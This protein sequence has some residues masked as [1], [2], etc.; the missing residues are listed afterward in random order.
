MEKCPGGRCEGFG[1]PARASNPPPGMAS[2]PR[3]GEEFLPSRFNSFVGRPRRPPSN[4]T[5]Q[6]HAPRLR[7]SPRRRPLESTLIAAAFPE[8][9][10]IN[11]DRAANIVAAPHHAGSQF[12]G[13]PGPRFEF[14]KRC[15]AHD[16][17]QVHADTNFA[18]RRSGL[19][20][21]ALR[22]PTI[23]RR[24]PET[25]IRTDSPRLLNGTVGGLW[26]RPRDSTI[27]SNRNL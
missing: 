4:R 11:A 23:E 8:H 19:L 18:N 12:S 5:A 1:R 15:C 2:N 20:A 22:R 16:R 13:R 10:F 7:G 21:Q 25:K 14:D 9:A 3:R 24:E 27:N 17:F 6:A 26:S